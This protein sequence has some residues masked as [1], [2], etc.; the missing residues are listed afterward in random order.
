MNWWELGEHSGYAGENPLSRITCAFCK[1]DGN[2]SVIHHEERKQ[3][4][5]AQKVLQYDTIKCGICGNLTM[6][7]WSRA[8][9]TMRHEIYDF[10]TV[11]WNTET[12]RHPDHWPKDVGRYW[13]QARRSLEGKNWDAASLMARSAIQLV[14]RYQG[15]KGNSLK[16]EID[17]LADK[18]LLPPIMKE[19]SHEVRELGNES[20]HPD[21]GGAG[22]DQ[23]DARDVVEFLDTLM[24]MTYNLPHQIE[25]YRKRKAGP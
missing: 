25:Q 13:L 7:F 11:P 15:A 23:K 9:T 22:T 12:V 2:F 4:N 14:A 19:W 3:P 6:V 17:D 10:K 24:V 18:G 21:P 5:R 1:N 20:T 8:A 16:Q